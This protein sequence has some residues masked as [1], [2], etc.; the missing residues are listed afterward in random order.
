[1][2]SGA[3]AAA[4]DS[5]SVLVV[6]T[7]PGQGGV[8]TARVNAAAHAFRPAH[9]LSLPS[10][11]ATLATDSFD[12]V[13]VHV[14]A[15]DRAAV[16]VAHAL[17]R[18][19]GA[20]ALVVVVDD[21]EGT[22]P[23]EL[24]REVDLV[25]STADLA[26]DWLLRLERTLETARLRRALR[27]AE[28]SVAQ[29]AGI[30]D[31]LVDPVFT[32]DA[33]GVV[34]SWNAAAARTYGYAADEIVGRPSA[35]LHPPGSDEHRRLLEV[36]L[37]GRAVR[38]V[39]TVLR[40]RDG[41]LAEASLDVAPL[42]GP[43]SGAV[44]VGHDISDR[45]ELE[46]E[47]VRQT[48]HDVLTGLPNRAFLTYR[49]TQTLSAARR[50]GSPVA[51]LVADLDQFKAV[52][53]MHGHHVGD[54]VL[55]AVADRLRDLAGPDGVVARLGGDEFV[56]VYPDTDVHQAGLMAERII[57]E[58]AVPIPVEH[59]RVRVGASVGIAVSPPLDDD[60]E[61]LLKHA[62]AAVYEAK[63][64]GRA[65]SQVYDHEFARR[66]AE[67]RRIAAD[68]QAALVYDRL[69]VH[70][71]PVFDLATG[72]MVS[73]EAL[74]RWSHPLHGSVSPATFISLAEEHGLI[75]ELDRWVLG[76]ACQETVAALL[77]GDIPPTTRV[78]V[79]L[80]AR[81]LD[82]AG[83]ADTVAE[84]VRR[85][86]LPP[87]SLVLEVTETAVLENMDAARRSLDGLR[88]LGAGVF[89]DDFGTGYS[90]LSFLREL[91]VTGVKIDRSFVSGVTERPE[92]VAI[93]EAIVRLAHGL[94]LETIAEGVETAEQRDLL[95]RL[96]CASA[97]GFW[98]SPAVP[99][100][101]LAPGRAPDRA[102]D[103]TPAPA[104]AAQP[105]RT[106]PGD[107]GA[108]R[109]W[110]SLSRRRGEVASAAPSVC[111]LRGGLEAGQGWLVITSPTRRD[112]FARVLGPLRT[113][114]LA[115]GQL[116][117]LDAYDT[118]RK[119]TGPDGNLDESSFE[120]VVGRQLRRLES[121]GGEVGVHAELGHVTQP[122]PS[123][124]VSTE[125]RTR[126][127]S[128]HRLGLAYGDRPAD[129][130]AHGPR[131]GVRSLPKDG[132]NAS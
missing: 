109:R 66:A 131:S 65:R 94:G 42:A 37:Q 32:V 64:R 72:R 43:D 90:S 22:A 113:A 69:E 10:A 2:L 63:A 12:C 86:G 46:A 31:S 117:E 4:G 58:L 49:L 73:M 41:Q 95:K 27:A 78:A 75:G 89:L 123:L 80:S 38:G 77:A 127:A 30:V 34:T 96:G 60:A 97:Q 3:V 76:R 107:R 11:L 120:E 99:M 88:A 93:T 101:R 15:A 110:S 8:L 98:W 53:D 54:R 112:A 48:M 35:V 124:R 7:Q 114:A 52:D 33:E 85:S 39:E 45:R 44:I 36:A 17:R 59:R 104:P 122:L 47:L 26:G 74:T 84:V 25:L 115:R 67:R 50:R 106:T 87:D 40:G 5:P 100:A 103:P 6:S 57:Q 119:V 121:A 62:D 81:S 108:A 83:I 126:L 118:L 18:R 20:A 13:L 55:A 102:A 116:V 132:T 16:E 24:D 79:N 125:L 129:C 28:S 68:L 51:V 9:A 130:A 23:P 128:D 105:R 82:D 71:Q 111:C 56:V 1:M 21:E 19:S 70:Y 61:T 14:G 91:P 92:D 29:L